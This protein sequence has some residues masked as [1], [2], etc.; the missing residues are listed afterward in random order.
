[1][2]EPKIFLI[3]GHSLLYRSFYA[4][5]HLSTSKGFPTNAIYGFMSIL[6]K[7]THEKKPQYLGIVFDT[8]GPTF[9]HKVFKN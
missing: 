3:D 4:I 5:K 8:K 2:R 6:K 9:R 1:M 7:L